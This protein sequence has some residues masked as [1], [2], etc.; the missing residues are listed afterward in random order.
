MT[1]VDLSPIWQALIGL[2][3]AALTA[4]GTA[5]LVAL[6]AKLNIQTTA[7]QKAVYDD[8]LYKALSSGIAQSMAQVQAHGWDKVDV[9]NAMVAS[10]LNSMVAKE[11]EALA[12]V[13]LSTDLSDS[14]NATLIRQA[15]EARLPAAI[16]TAAAS[17]A[18]P[19][20]VQDKFAP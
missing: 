7:S 18:T 6:R 12:S 1:T 4:A 14:R 17:P 5:A 15:L 8:A 19:A 10:A 13:G 11:P 20:I 9:H 3:A 16:S 2:C